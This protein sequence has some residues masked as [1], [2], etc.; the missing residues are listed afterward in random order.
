MNTQQKAGDFLNRF[1][2][3]GGEVQ[4][5]VLAL[6]HVSRDQKRAVF[7]ELSQEHA[8]YQL[9]CDQFMQRKGIKLKSFRSACQRRYNRQLLTEAIQL[10]VP[11]G[12]TRKI[13]DTLFLMTAE[14]VVISTRVPPQT[15]EEYITFLERIVLCV[16]LNYPGY[17][18]SRLLVPI[19]VMRMSGRL[20]HNR[21]KE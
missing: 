15:E 17:R 21:V 6:L 1:Y 20:V 13:R 9:I 3:L 4:R 5:A 2:E 11:A 18:R 14:A 12:T 10:I 16:E 8:L 19:A 7:D